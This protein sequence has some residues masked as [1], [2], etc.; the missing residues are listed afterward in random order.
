MRKAAYIAGTCAWCSGIRPAPHV[1]H[2]LTLLQEAH[3][4]AHIGQPSQ[5]PLTDDH[6]TMVNEL[7]TDALHAKLADANADGRLTFDEYAV[8]EVSSFRDTPEQKALSKT[9]TQRRLERQVSALV[10]T[11]DSNGNGILDVA[12]L[13]GGREVL[14]QFTNPSYIS[15][16]KEEL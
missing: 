8:A 9:K 16:L 14:E 13:L 2:H 6:P 7:E 10:R 5:H 11:I 3:A 4:A 15:K 1:A 12:E